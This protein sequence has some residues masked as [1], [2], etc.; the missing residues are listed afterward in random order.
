MV[1]AGISEGIILVASVIVAASL[2]GVVLSKAG[3]LNS[4]FTVSSENQKEITLTKIKIVYA[5][6][7]STSPTFSIWVKN[8]GS[9]P[10]KNTDKVDV[11]F[12]AVGATN[13]IPYNAG[14]NPKWVYNQ[15]TTVWQVKDTVQINVTM[16]ANLAATT[17]YMVRV[18]TPNGVTDEYIFST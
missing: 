6:G 4:A 10:V 14:S 8:I 7:T 15:A 17:T 13:M 12:G 18:S 3:A 16:T 2:S 11:Y 1:S 5:N 9:T